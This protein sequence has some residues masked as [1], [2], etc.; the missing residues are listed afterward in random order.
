MTLTLVGIAGGTASGKTTAARALQERLGDR[1]L[2]LT[3]DRYYHPLPARY[4]ADPT[5]YNFDHPDALDTARMVRDLRALRSGAT[6]RVPRYDYA[7]HVRLPPS[8]WEVVHPRPVVLVE[9]ILVL[10]DPALRAELDHRVYVHAPDDIRLLRRIRRDADQRGRSVEEVL[11]QYL[12]T[13]R[14]MHEAFVAPSRQHADLVVDGTRSPD[15]M[16]ASVL[17]LIDPAGERSTTERA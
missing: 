7:R 5:A 10:A 9:G 2:C 6:V 11:D 3:H 15:A 1:C 16:V 17:D 12:R 4:R 13:V 14:P 8:Q